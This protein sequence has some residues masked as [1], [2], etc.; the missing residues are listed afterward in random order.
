MRSS[1]LST[2]A[3]GKNPAD[4]FPCA[5]RFYLRRRETQALE[6]LIP[7][8][9]EMDID[10]VLG[11]PDPRFND[12]IEDSAQKAGARCGSTLQY[13]GSRTG[14]GRGAHGSP[15]LVLSIS[16]MERAG[17]AA[18]GAWIGK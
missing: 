15:L 6:T 12:G 2:C 16:T 14:H 1:G 13:S 11:F 17:L 18:A 10:S 9:R 4:G 8:S 7:D 3:P 5:D